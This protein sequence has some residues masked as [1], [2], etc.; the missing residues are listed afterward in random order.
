MSDVLTEIRERVHGYWHE[1]PV[2][3]FEP[4]KHQLV[5]ETCE[6]AKEHGVTEDEIDEWARYRQ[7]ELTVGVVTANALQEL[8]ARLRQPGGVMRFRARL[9]RDRERR[10]G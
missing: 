4:P 10:N 5:R 9:V 2:W 8:Q 7:G 1:A 3:E 6:L